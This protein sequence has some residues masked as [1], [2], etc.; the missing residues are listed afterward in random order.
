MLTRM[1]SSVLAQVDRLWTTWKDDTRESD[2][3]SDFPIGFDLSQIEFQ[4]QEEHEEDQTEISDPLEDLQTRCWPDG[5][6]PTVGVDCEQR[7]PWRVRGTKDNTPMD[8][9]YC[10]LFDFIAVFH[11]CQMNKARCDQEFDRCFERDLFRERINQ[12]KLRENHKY[13]LYRTIFFNAFVPDVARERALGTE[14]QINVAPENIRVHLWDYAWRAKEAIKQNL[15]DSHWLLRA[16]QS[17]IH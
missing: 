4:V 8:S 12:F 9:N 13:G 5:G 15:H 11:Y 6:G 1:N 17:K 2:W 14:I 3:N 7:L 10:Y 16:A